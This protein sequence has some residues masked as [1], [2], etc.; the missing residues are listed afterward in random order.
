M[1]FLWLPS[2]CIA[3]SLRTLVGRPNL[4]LK[5]KPIQPRPRFSGRPLADCAGPGRGSRLTRRHSST[6]RQVAGLPRPSVRRQLW[7]GSE[8]ALV[9]PAGRQ[10]F[11]VGA[12]DVDDQYVHRP[13]VRRRAGRREP[14]TL[15]RP[16]P[17][18]MRCATLS[19]KRFVPEP[20]TQTLDFRQDLAG[21]GQRIRA[22]C[23][24]AEPVTAQD[25]SLYGRSERI[26]TSDP[27]VPNDVRY[28]AA[29]HSDIAA[30]EA[31]ELAL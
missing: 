28:Q 16:C 9:G 21:A 8:L 18:S 3:G 1:P 10:D 27:I 2:A 22:R 17:A 13:L 19:R 5:S 20:R 6:H 31:S 23:D 26:R 11:D 7:S 25:V 30:L 14:G 12:A 4:V 29:L 15:Q 24:P